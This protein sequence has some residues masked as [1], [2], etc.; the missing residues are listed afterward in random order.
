MIYRRLNSLLVTSRVEKSNF[1]KALEGVR[2]WDWMS[3]ADV[4]NG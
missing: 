3:E 2:E 1:Y 4:Q